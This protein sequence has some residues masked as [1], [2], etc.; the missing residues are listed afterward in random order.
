MGLT[1]AAARVGQWASSERPS[2]SSS[3]NR[4][5]SFSSLSS[6]QSVYFSFYYSSVSSITDTRTEVGSF[7]NFE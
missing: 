3:N 4:R 6:S 2:Q 7:G 5:G 1:E